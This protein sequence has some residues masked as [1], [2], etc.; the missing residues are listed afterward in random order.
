ML[1]TKNSVLAWRFIHHRNKAQFIAG[2]ALDNIAIPTCNGG[3]SE[4]GDK[5]EGMLDEQNIT[6]SAK[7]FEMH[8][9]FLGSINWKYNEIVIINQFPIV[10]H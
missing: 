1:V 4:E 9:K 7:V 5:K 8:L 6:Q 2:I 10:R 3:I